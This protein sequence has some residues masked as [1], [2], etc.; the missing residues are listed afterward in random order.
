MN[1]HSLAP[2]ATA[3]PHLPPL[4]PTPS[5]L[6]AS[7]QELQILSPLLCRTFLALGL[8][9]KSAAES[10]ECKGVHQGPSPP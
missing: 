3:S 1:T 7:H 6:P 2:L 5:L 4:P 10:Y 8:T 9:A